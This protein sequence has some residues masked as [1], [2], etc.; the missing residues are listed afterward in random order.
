MST[1]LAKRQEASLDTARNYSFADR[2]DERELHELKWFDYRFMAPRE[3]TALFAREYAVMYRRCYAANVDTEESEHKFGL[4]NPLLSPNR[5]ELTSLWRAR[6]TA[7]LLGVPYNVFLDAA[8]KRLTQGLSRRVPYI[9]Q[10]YGK[11]VMLIATAVLTQWQE[12]REDTLKVSGLHAYR[13]NAFVGLSA[14]RAHREWVIGEIK[15]RHG[16]PW[17]IGSA[18]FIEKVLPPE[19]AEAT[20]GCEKMAMAR[21]SVEGHLPPP[22]EPEA[23]EKLLP[24]C[25]TL[26]GAFDSAAVECSAC[27]FVPECARAGTWISSSLT[28]ELGSEDPISFRRRKLQAA[29]TQ[30]CRAKKRAAEDRSSGT[31]TKGG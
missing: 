27:P 14:Q 11:R 12:I 17:D 4:R 6:Q 22:C 26:P 24:S 13:E 30:K 23:L 15:A 28:A 1:T 8:F 3:A 5:A 18:C 21:A 25:A 2:L 9:N 20:F 10:M 16:R 7:D 31:G 19:L 29:R